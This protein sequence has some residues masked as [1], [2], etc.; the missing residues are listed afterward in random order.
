MF[1]LQNIIHFRVFSIL[2]FQYNLMWKRYIKFAWK[3]IA[4]FKQREVNLS[5]LPKSIKSPLAPCL[6]KR[7]FKFGVEGEK[8]DI[9]FQKF[10]NIFLIVPRS[11]TCSYRIQWMWKS[12]KIM[13]VQ[14]KPDLEPTHYKNLLVAMRTS[15]FYLQARFIKMKH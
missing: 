1:L 6:Q 8:V 7:W 3:T 5:K 11:K 13:S 12:Q 15:N 2:Y 14:T 9:R 10:P 4:F